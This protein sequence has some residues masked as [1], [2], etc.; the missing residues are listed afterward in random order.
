MIRYAATL[1]YAFS[2]VALGSA[3]NISKVNGGI[4][5]D[6]GQ[7]AGDLSTVNG[8]IRVGR[9]AQVR[10]VETVNGSIRLESTASAQAVETVN[11]GVTLEEDTVV[12]GEVSAVNGKMTLRRGARVDGSVENVNGAFRLESATVRGGLE[13]V[14]GDVFVGAG[15]LIEGGILVEKQRGWSWSH[16]EPPSVTIE[17]GATV[18]GPIRFEREVDLY[19]GDGA[20]IGPIQGVEPRRHTLH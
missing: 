1:L 8:S 6:P 12:T 16:S 19:V 15:S 3:V 2:A 20:E 5:I 4:D 11:G 7:Q 18:K 13:T 9:G 14:N 17:S 10:D